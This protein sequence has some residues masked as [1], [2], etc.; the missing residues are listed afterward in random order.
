MT[1]KNEPHDF[2][3]HNVLDRDSSG[4]AIHME[5]GSE[6]SYIA[7]ALGGAE[8]QIRVVKMDGELVAELRSTEGRLVI[9]PDVANVVYIKVQIL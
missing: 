3:K 7:L 9:I 2:T 5:D 6:P 4:E 8:L 1:K